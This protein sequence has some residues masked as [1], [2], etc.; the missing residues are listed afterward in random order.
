MTIETPIFITFFGYL[1][2]MMAI[3]FWAFKKTD[4]VGDYILGGRKMGPA[5]TALSVGASDMSGWLLLGLPGAVYLGGLGESWIGFGLIFGAWLNWLFVAKRL[6]VYTELA[7]NALTLP[8]FFENRFNDPKG[9]IRLLSAITILVFFTFYASSGMVG[10]AILFEKV[11][12]L[13]YTTA[14]LIGSFIIVSYTF[15]GGFFAVSW[16]DF[17]QGCLM[18]I[19]LVFVPVVIFSEPEIQHNLSVIDP[20]ML[21]FISDET[22]LIGLISLLAW[23]LGYFGQPH[24]LSRFMAIGQVSDLPL[25]RR[26][27]MGWMALALIGS[28]ATG[29]AGSLYFANSPIEN[30]ETVFIQLTHAVFNPWIG[31]LLIAAILS[32]IMSTID[33]QLLVCSSVVTEDFYL[34]WLRPQAS[35]KELILVGRFGVIAIAL[36]AGVVALDPQSSVL[37][38]VSYAWAG[39]GAAFGPVVLLSLFWQGYSRNGAIA[40]ILAGAITVVVWKQ[41]SGGI[42]ELY[43]ILPGFALALIFGVVVS[44]ISPPAPATTE[45]FKAFNA[46]L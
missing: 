29:I 26:I 18:L 43:E 2:L 33:S 40:S 9:V 1:A 38:L 10:G 35:D 46:S 34:K 36:V 8:D 6:R 44:K 41:L 12:G 20:A 27:A 15:V 7:D 42:F 45:G 37:G 23:G 22:S 21:N 11:F 32:A 17:F 25:S 30:A 16:T 19:A 24:I 4:T 28:L 14:L 13:D 39:F 5:V 3:G 31:G